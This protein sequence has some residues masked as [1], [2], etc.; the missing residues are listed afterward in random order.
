MFKWIILIKRMKPIKTSE[1]K[2]Q[3]KITKELLKWL[4]IKIAD[5]G[6]ELFSFVI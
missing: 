4:E 6:S 3:Y 2:N 5:I 1:T